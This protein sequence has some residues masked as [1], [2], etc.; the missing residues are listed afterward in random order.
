MMGRGPKGQP[1]DTAGTGSHCTNLR[2]SSNRED[3]YLPQT[4]QTAA[5][6]CT[7]V[8]NHGSKG[9]QSKE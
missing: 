5:V 8:G 7:E 3:I 2:L 1:H 6:G 4:Q 9:Q